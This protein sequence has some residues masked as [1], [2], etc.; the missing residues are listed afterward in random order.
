[1]SDYVLAPVAREDL[2]TIWNYY[3]SELGDIDLAD[4]IR[5]EIFAGIAAVA[6]TP[7]LGH[8]RKDLA[9]ERLRFWLVRKYLIIYRADKKP[10]EVVRVLHSGRDVQAILGKAG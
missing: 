6:R 9:H 1:M 3:A 7:G 5:D 4:R 2:L 8:L 10:L